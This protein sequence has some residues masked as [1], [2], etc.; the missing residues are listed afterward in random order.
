M[1]F[2]RSYQHALLTRPK[3]T[4]FFTTGFLFGSGDVFAQVLFPTEAPVLNNSDDSKRYS[5]DYARTLRAA[6]YGSFIFSFIGDKW[7]RILSTVKFPGAALK[8]Q[9]LNTLRNTI[10]RTAVD[11]LG[12]APVGIPLY[13]TVMSQL[14]GK[15]YKETKIKL[16][17]NWWPT[18][19]ANWTVWPLFQL[20]NLGLVPV[21]HQLLTVNLI[22][23]AWN[24]YL[25]LRNSQQVIQTP[26]YSPPI[27][28]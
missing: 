16:E 7:Y 25:S 15:S 14:E 6:F 23:I 11:Q 27:P 8:N 17:E 4:N 26:V 18:L 24:T 21:Q 3:L 9:K 1:S 22:S 12:W 20:F 19:K 28:E 2:F 5:Y 13:F 10:A